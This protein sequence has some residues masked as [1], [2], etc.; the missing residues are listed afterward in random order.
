MSAMI[1]IIIII[2]SPLNKMKRCSYSFY[3]GA[4][5]FRL[6][7]H[8]PHRGATTASWRSS[9]SALRVEPRGSGSCSSCRGCSTR[10]SCGR[11]REG[12]DQTKTS[13]G[14]NR[15]GTGRESISLGRISCPARGRHTGCSRPESLVS[16]VLPLS[17]NGDALLPA[18]S[19]APR[20]REV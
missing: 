1:I 2:I 12:L 14:Y 20:S 13:A 6:E 10:G 4:L 16:G 15:T 18:A 17:W 19:G 8:L 5:S 9:K 3:R 7:R 11:A